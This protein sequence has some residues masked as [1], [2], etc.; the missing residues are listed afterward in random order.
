MS[1]CACCVFIHDCSYENVSLFFSY[2]LFVLI[3]NIQNTKLHIWEMVAIKSLSARVSHSK[4]QPKLNYSHCWNCGA[5]WLLPSPVVIVVVAFCSFLICN[6][7]STM[8][9]IGVL[10]VDNVSTFLGCF[11]YKYIVKE[12]RYIEHDNRPK[13]QIT[14]WIQHNRKQKCLLNF[15]W[16][17]Q[18]VQSATM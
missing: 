14:I 16:F 1:I 6:L 8:D 9:M 18:I 5:D 2:T 11:R 4:C 7:S 13:M 12:R 17:K 3:I 10:F 15:D